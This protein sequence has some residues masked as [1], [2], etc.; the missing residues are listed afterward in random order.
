MSSSGTSGAADTR[1]VEHKIERPQRVQ[2]VGEEV[3]YRIG[4][5]HITELAVV[6]PADGGERA[7]ASS[8]SVLFDVTDGDVRPGVT[9]ASRTGQTNASACTGYQYFFAFQ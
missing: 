4:A 2:A 7:S 5:G 9:N 6:G 1:V 3:C 8:R